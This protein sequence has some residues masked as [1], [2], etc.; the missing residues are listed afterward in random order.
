MQVDCT[1]VRHTQ[2]DKKQTRKLA[3]HLF[4]A[5]LTTVVRPVLSFPP[6]TVH[7]MWSRHS[8]SWFQVENKSGSRASEREEK[9][10]KWD[11]EGPETSGGTGSLHQRA[12]LICTEQSH[13]KWSEEERGG[14]VRDS[15]KDEGKQWGWVAGKRGGRDRETEVRGEQCFILKVKVTE[16]KRSCGARGEYKADWRQ[17]RINVVG[18]LR[19]LLPSREFPANVS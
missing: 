8:Q 9:I 12:T 13:C 7:W 14:D 17:G 4:N 15:A 5:I 11:S 16:W 2:G 10:C 18:C 6:K 1:A 19:A 3:W